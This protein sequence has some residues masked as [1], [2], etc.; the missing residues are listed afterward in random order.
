[1]KTS[2]IS[3]HVMRRVYTAYALS[4]AT[5]VMF[6]QGLFLSVAV[7]L[8]G[9]WLH[10]ASI[11][12]NILATPVGSVPAYVYNSFVTALQNGEVTMV[13]MFL[14]AGGVAISAGY[15]IAH[16]IASYSSGVKRI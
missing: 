6:W 5:H 1:M 12:H 9:R 16:F 13:L 2:H 14:L 8:L 4:I 10:V 7:L 15:Q 3:K 11:Y